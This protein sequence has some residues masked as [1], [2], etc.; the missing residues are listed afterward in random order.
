MSWFASELH[1]HTVH[2]DGKFT[3]EQLCRA[4]K[5]REL[6]LIALTDHNTASG[7]RFLTKALEEETVPVIRGIEWTTFFG[8]ML[9]LGCGKHVDW[10]YVRPPE[11]DDR[12]REIHENGGIVG[13]A[14][15]F[16]IGSPM[17]TAAWMRERL[18]AMGVRPINNIVDITNYVMLEYGQPMHSFDYACLKGSAIDVRLARA[19]EHFNT[20]D[21]Q[22]RNLTEDML[23]IADSVR[24]VAVAGAGVCDIGAV[25][26]PHGT[27]NDRFFHWLQ[28]VPAA[29]RQFTE[30]QD[31]V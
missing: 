29:C 17:Y 6:S 12:I 10:R 26:D 16:S 8:H 23:V 31:K 22:E 9:V 15:P 3:V 30:R 14:H 28:T 18:R 2:S 21:G 19:G 24:P 13:M 5:E 20:L 4:A 7:L 27:V 25:H 11:I 1:T